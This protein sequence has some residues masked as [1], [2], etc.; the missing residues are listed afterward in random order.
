MKERVRKLDRRQRRNVV[1][2]LSWGLSFTKG[3]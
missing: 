3:R 1:T 2:D